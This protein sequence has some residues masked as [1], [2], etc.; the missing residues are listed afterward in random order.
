MASELPTLAACPHCGTILL[1][2]PGMLVHPAPEE[3]ATMRRALGLFWFTHSRLKFDGRFHRCAGRARR[4][5]RATSQGPESA[6]PTGAARLRQ[7][8]R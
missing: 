8:Q 4:T 3:R 1:W 7:R 6:P 2:A 5:H